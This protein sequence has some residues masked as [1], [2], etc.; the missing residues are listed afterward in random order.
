MTGATVEASGRDFQG[1]FDGVALLLKLHREGG[2]SVATSRAGADRCVA[3]STLFPDGDLTTRLHTSATEADTVR[4]FA[5]VR[6]QSAAIGRARK[7]LVAWVGVAGSAGVLALTG[8]G[9]DASWLTWIGGSGVAAQ[10]IASVRFLWRTRTPA[11]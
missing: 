3:H 6:A 4:H 10:G 1:A 2:L 7:A 8:W 11:T 9:T 5:A